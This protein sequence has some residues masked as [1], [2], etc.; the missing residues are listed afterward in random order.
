MGLAKTRIGRAGRLIGLAGGVVLAIG[1]SACT[2]IEGTN[3]L[4]D[5]GTFEREV[6]TSTL[7]GLGVVPRGEK[8]ETNQRRGPLVLPKDGVAPPAPRDRKQVAAIPVDSD[9]VQIDMTGMSQQ[10]LQRLRNARVVDLTSVSGRPLT[11]DEARKLTAR[12]KGA[13][14]VAGKRPIYMPPE[15]YFTVVNGRETVCLARNGD[16]V[17][18]DDKACPAEI[19]KALQKN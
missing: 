12:M 4:T 8:E 2:T 3:A 11:A 5:V 7:V 19:R 15:E 18:I 10:D 9:E 16:V 14:M 13:K 17:P 6:M 1:L